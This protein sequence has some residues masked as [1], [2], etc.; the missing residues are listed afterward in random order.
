VFERFTDRGRRVVVY[1]QEESRLLHHDFIGSEHLLLALL[2]DDEVIDETRTA[3]QQAGLTLQPARRYIEQ[4]RGRGRK[5]LHGHIPFS[6]RAKKILELSMR[7]SQRLDGH[8]IGEPH[9]LRAMLN[10]PDS[11]AYQVLAG[12]GVDAEALS[13]VADELALACQAQNEGGGSALGEASGAA[14]APPAASRPI[15]RGSYRAY[16]QSSD[17]LMARAEELTAQRDALAMAVRRYGRHDDTCQPDRGCTCGL[18]QVLD[19][20]DRPGT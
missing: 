4:L 8:V 11:T 2:H 6:P 1:A 13:R 15:A 18:Q 9:L 10:V 7:V 17:R 14:T 3:L 19:D 5:E 20:I 12:F 16:G